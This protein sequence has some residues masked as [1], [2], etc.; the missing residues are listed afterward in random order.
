M[1][2][3]PNPASVI[4]AIS[5]ILVEGATAPLTATGTGAEFAFN[6]EVQPAPTVAS[7]GPPTGSFNGGSPV[8]ISGT[9][10]AAVSAVSF[11]GAAAKSFTVGSESQLTAVAPAVER[12]GPVDITVT[13]AAGTSTVTAADRFTYTAC[14]VPKLRDRKLVT[15][16]RKLKKAGCRVGKVTRRQGATAKTGRG[17]RPGQ[18]GRPRAGTRDQGLRHARLSASGSSARDPRIR[19][20]RSRYMG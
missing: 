5:P 15:A 8:T 12:T 10:F 9:D 3:I 14:V 19:T 7:V 18:G 13:T 1:G 20:T 11:G 4:G 17:R 16:K 2:A 6:A